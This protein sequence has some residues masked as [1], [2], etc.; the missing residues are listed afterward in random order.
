MTTTRNEPGADEHHRSPDQTH[1]ERRLLSPGRRRLFVCIILIALVLAQELACRWMFPLPECAGFNR[2]NYTPVHFFGDDVQDARHRGLSNAKL[3]VE[4]E[5]D[6][7]VFD[8]ALNLYGFR[9]PDFRLDPPADRPRI[10]FIG[11]SFTEGAGAADDDT[12][13]EQFNRIMQ[14]K[15]PVEAVNLGISGTGLGDYALIARDSVPLLRPKAVFLVT[16][17][18]DAPAPP[19]ADFWELTEPAPKFVR[20]SPW[21]PRAA[22]AIGRWWAGEVVPSRFPSGPFH[23]HAP[24]P[25]PT[26]PLSSQPPPPNID[27]KILKAI[28]RGKLHPWTMMMAAAHEKVL[29]WDFEKSG[30]AR[31][32]L[33]Y[34]VAQCQRQDCQLIVVYIPHQVTTN[35]AYMEGQIKLGADYGKVTRLDGPEYRGSQRHLRQVTAALGVPFLDTT[36]AFIDAEKQQGGMFWP[37]DGHCTAAG[38]RLV[39]DVCARYWHNGISPGA[40]EESAIAPVR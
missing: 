11:D 34:I 19:I 9:G 20:N 12:I 26:N 22:A 33:E 25:S 38:Y 16:C 32:Y 3:R 6:G 36:A 10:L 39:A 37:I 4:S 5:P 24:V 8:H 21:M 30:S 15:Q 17:F 13:P 18:N 40:K 7:F 1:V 23:F 14:R 27:P 35:P 31:E 29:R 28:E 2:M